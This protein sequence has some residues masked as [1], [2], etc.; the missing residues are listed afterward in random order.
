MLYRSSAGM[1]FWWDGAAG[2]GGGRSRRSTQPRRTHAASSCAMYLMYYVDEKGV[3]VRISFI[4]GG[5][6]RGRRDGSKQG[7]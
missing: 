7:G 4:V 6:G 1:V 3:K 5:G 2:L